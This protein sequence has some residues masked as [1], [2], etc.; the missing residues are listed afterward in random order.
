[1]SFSGTLGEWTLQKKKK[2][3]RKLLR[4]GP[5]DTTLPHVGEKKDW[6]GWDGGVVGWKGLGGLAPE[7]IIGL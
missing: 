5:W 7:V 6:D 3:G 4:K 1:M 2:K